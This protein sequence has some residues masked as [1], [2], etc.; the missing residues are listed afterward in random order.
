MKIISAQIFEDNYGSISGKG[1]DR[2]EK[3]EALIREVI[4]P[5]HFGESTSASIELEGCHWDMSVNKYPGDYAD[6]WDLT[7]FTRDIPACMHILFT[8]D[9][10]ELQS[11][12]QTGHTPDVLSEEYT[13]GIMEYVKSNKI[14]TGNLFFFEGHPYMLEDFIQNEMGT[15]IKAM[16]INMDRPVEVGEIHADTRIALHTAAPFVDMQECT[17]E[18]QDLYMNKFMPQEL[19]LLWD[20]EPGEKIFNSEK[21]VV[22]MLDEG[23]ST[24]TDKV[25][26]MFPVLD[27]VRIGLPVKKEK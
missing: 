24:D 22:F 25:F 26:R 11:L 2:N 14:Q 21:M 13:Q 1:Y 18:H 3:L 5:E 15:Y 16:P 4:I 9:A 20:I 7:L 8:I 17:Q 10:M 19:V 27:M 12:E 6:L 23:Q